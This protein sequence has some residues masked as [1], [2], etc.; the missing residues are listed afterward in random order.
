MNTNSPGP[1]PRT[2]FSSKS[3]S[4]SFGTFEKSSFLEILLKN[5]KDGIFDAKLSDLNNISAE[6]KDTALLEN[7]RDVF[8]LQL[9][10]AHK[11]L[12]DT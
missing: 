7:V 4:F 2:K 11:L 5:L 1:P 10:V 6:K 12:L 8:L 3:S 9:L